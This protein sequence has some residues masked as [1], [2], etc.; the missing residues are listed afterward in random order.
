[1]KRTADPHSFSQR[2]I[3]SRVFY[4]SMPDVVLADTTVRRGNHLPKALHVFATL[5]EKHGVSAYCGI[6]LLHRHWDVDDG[7]FPEQIR[8]QRNG[9]NELVT[10][11]VF[12]REMSDCL[13]GSWAMQGSGKGAN[14][15]PFEFTTDLYARECAKQLFEK[16]ELFADVRSA[17]LDHDLASKFGICVAVREAL[18]DNPA[19]EFVETSEPGRQSV[20]VEKIQTQLEREKSIQTVWVFD[21]AATVD[22][23]VTGTRCIQSCKSSPAHCEQIIRFPNH[24]NDHQYIEAS[25][26]SDHREETDHKEVDNS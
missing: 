25:H 16:P 24:D 12:A 10:R 26:D 17:L 8:R 4:N 14:F 5:F 21:S 15:S 1:M 22:C 6:N 7:E 19:A 23:Q 11:P 20:V 18:S 2:R 9:E 13:P 3:F